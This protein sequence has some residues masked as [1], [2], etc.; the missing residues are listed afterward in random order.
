MEVEGPKLEWSFRKG[1]PQTAVV[2]DSRYGRLTIFLPLREKH[3]CQRKFYKATRF[4]GKWVGSQKSFLCLL[5]TTTHLTN[6]S[7]SLW[8]W[9]GDISSSLWNWGGDSE[10]FTSLLS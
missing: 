3:W 2:H 6:I 7:S 10:T 1:G 8:N 5:F 9:G 4:S